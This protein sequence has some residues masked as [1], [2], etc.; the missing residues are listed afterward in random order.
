MNIADLLKQFITA[1][2]I[3][4]VAFLAAL[5]LLTGCATDPSVVGRPSSPTKVETFVVPEAPGLTWTRWSDGTIT[6]SAGHEGRTDP[7]I[8]LCDSR[9]ITS[10]KKRLAS[11]GAYAAE[12]RVR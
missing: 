4:F 7:R 5:A 12:C 9:T 2:A 1:A 6:S 8:P 3:F 11:G 10:D